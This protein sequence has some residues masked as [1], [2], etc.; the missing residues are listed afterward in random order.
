[1]QP[2]FLSLVASFVSLRLIR[3]PCASRSSP[4]RITHLPS[5]ITQSPSM[6][7]TNKTD[8]LEPDPAFSGLHDPYLGS[9]GSAGVG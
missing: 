7:R 9:R 6:D 8:K 5:C 4:S 3:R 1:L 2:H